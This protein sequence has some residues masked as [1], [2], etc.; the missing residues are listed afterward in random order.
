MGVGGK[1][2]ILDFLPAVTRVKAGTTVAFVNRSSSEVHNVTFGPLK[3]IDKFG[4]QMDLFPMGPN[5]KNQTTPILVYASDPKPLTYEAGIH[6]NGF[7]AG[8]LTDGMSGGLPN[9][10]RITFMSPGKYHFICFI[11]GPDMAANVIVTK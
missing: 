1:T 10:T 3:Y 5:S 11:H 8:P 7:F 6:G 2:A 4:K 9:T